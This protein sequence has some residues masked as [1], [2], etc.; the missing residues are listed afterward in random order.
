MHDDFVPGAGW[1]P[2]SQ[3]GV[4]VDLQRVAVDVCDQQVLVAPD[5][6][7][8]GREPAVKGDLRPRAAAGQVRAKG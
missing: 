8:I 1:H 2:G 3:S 6:C 4:V 5:R 7:R